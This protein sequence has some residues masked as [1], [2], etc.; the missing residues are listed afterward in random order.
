MPFLIH[1]ATI[2]CVITIVRILKCSDFRMLQSNVE[3]FESFNALKLAGCWCVFFSLF[4]VYVV[5]LLVLE[6]LVAGK[7]KYTHKTLREKC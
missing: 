5:I 2:I 6:M 4:F 1:N 7:Q 3:M